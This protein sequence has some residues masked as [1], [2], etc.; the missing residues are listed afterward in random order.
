V[1]IEEIFAPVKNELEQFEIKFNNALHSDVPLADQVV[2]YISKR[3]GKRLRPVLVFLSGKLHG[4][5]TPKTMNASIVIELLHTATLVHDDVVDNSDLRRGSPTVN[6]LWDN[7]ISVLVGDLLFSR[8]L[9]AMLELYDL[10]ALAILS[11][12]AK[13]V[14]EGELLQIELDHD[15]EMDEG[16]YFDLISKKTAALFEASCELGALS[17]KNDSESRLRM[18]KFGKNLGIAFQIKDDLL[19]YI[20]SSTK[21]GKPTG[22]DIRENKVTLPLIYALANAK[23]SDRQRILDIMDQED[24]NDEEINQI[25]NFVKERGGVDYS[26]AIAKSYAE[27]AQNILNAYPESEI[28]TT[29]KNLVDF[30]VNREN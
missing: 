24:R 12:A 28:R 19:D 18:K 27:K 1:N 21:I 16:T 11:D 20:G 2:R 3:R 14:T 29:L 4:E 26:F 9:T 6:N 25:I 10:E 5:V 22:N 23:A 17:I 30:A 13:L 8:T 15:F 7:K